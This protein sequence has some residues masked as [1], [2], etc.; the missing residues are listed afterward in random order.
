[1]SA[2]KPT[3]VTVQAIIKAP[4]EKVWKYWSEPEHIMKWNAASDD[5]HT[6]RSENDLRVG[7]KFTSRMEAKDGSMG[8]DFG[9]TYDV[10]TLHEAIS[11][12]MGDGRRVDTSFTAQGDETN[13]V[14]TFDAEETNPVEFQQQGWQAIMDNFKSYTETH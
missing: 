11:Y 10:V 8:F 6:P 4:V 12:T 5:W 13:V 3:K 7:G 9:G 1:M 2:N 14:Q